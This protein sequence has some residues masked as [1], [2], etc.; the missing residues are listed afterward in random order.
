MIRCLG[1]ARPR[2][3]HLHLTHMLSLHALRG[4][5]QLS[6]PRIKADLNGH[7]WFGIDHCVL[8]RVQSGV[9][10]CACVCAQ[11]GVCISHVHTRV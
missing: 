7:W 5:L 9:H 6:D 2:V 10:I 8:E 11:E 1:G 4:A 3:R